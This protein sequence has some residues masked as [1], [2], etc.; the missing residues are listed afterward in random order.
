MAQVRLSEGRLADGL[1]CYV[2]ER[3]GIIQTG[4]DEGIRTDKGKR[5]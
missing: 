3:N 2:E 5:I 1:L 4:W